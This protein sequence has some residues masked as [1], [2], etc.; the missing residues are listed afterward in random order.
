MK[1]FS[2][3]PKCHKPMLHEEMRKGKGI[4]TWNLSCQSIDHEIIAVTAHG[5]DNELVT[6]IVAIKMASQTS[7]RVYVHWNFDMDQ[8]FIVNGWSVANFRNPPL[9]PYFEPDLSQYDKL[10][11]K[12]RT[13]LTFS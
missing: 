10:I 13:Y 5:N 2:H 4:S 1:T 9:L 6:F 8:V 3:C 12:L 7:D 11:K